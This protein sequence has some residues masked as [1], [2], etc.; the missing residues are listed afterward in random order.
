MATR[1]HTDAAARAAIPVAGPVG[2][3]GQAM[4]VG[5]VAEIQRSRLLS[6]AVRA[7]EEVGY[8]EA[9]V[10]H[11][12]GRARVSRR[13]FYEQFAN[14]EECIA[15]ALE[16]V[17]ALIEEELA[18]AELDGLP[19]RDRVRGGLWA[20]LSFL[21]REPAL[22]HVL[23][24]EALR[25]GPPVLSL[26]DR[27]LARLTAVVDQGR[28]TG[29]RAGSAGSLAA[30]G[31]VGAALS[32]VHARLSNGPT[33]PLRDLLGE[34][35]GLIVLPY[36]G[37]AAARQEQARPQPRPAKSAEHSQGKP[38][39]ADGDPLEGLSMRLTYRT[40]RVLECVSVEPGLSN[41]ALGAAAGIAD[42]GQVSKLL[43]RL[44]RLGLL[45]ND[46]PGHL[47]GEP[48]AWKLTAQG[49][50]VVQSVHTRLADG[51]RAA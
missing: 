49:D 4:P 35:M 8:A 45:A 2:P 23:I 27:V 9:T 37:V 16:G 3:R 20:I 1:A 51:R 15:V 18:A 24:V 30:E 25:G 29:S 50:L 13:T 42:Q 6:A 19:W 28:R 48:N 47:K 36:L 44:E 46:G 41:R 14:R 17:V 40:M 31:L 32:I 26:R 10:A 7:V 38:A 11:I 39:R 5:Q 22:A 34:M 21:D 12:T 33:A 43:A